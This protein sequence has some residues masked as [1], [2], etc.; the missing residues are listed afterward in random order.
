MWVQGKGDCIKIPSNSMLALLVSPTHSFLFFKKVGT[1][2]NIK[3]TKSLKLE[4][5]GVFKA[6]SYFGLVS[7]NSL[8]TKSYVSRVKIIFPLRR[9]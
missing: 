3:V 8:C 2:K 4:V 7:L 6:R 5:W 9:V 1:D